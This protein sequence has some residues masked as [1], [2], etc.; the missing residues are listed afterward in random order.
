MADQNKF[1][2]LFK[3]EVIG[4]IEALT[5]IAPE[6]SEHKVENVSDGQLTTP[7]AQINI[8]IGGE[9]SGKMAIFV[10]VYL[11]TALGDMMLAGEGAGKDD[12]T[13]EDLDSIKEITSN[14]VGSFS[15][16]IS[17]QKKDFPSMS[18]RPLEAIFIDKDQS[19]NISDMK[20]HI[21]FNFNLNGAD[22]QYS[23]LLDK[24]YSDIFEK[25]NKKDTPKEE[26]K[27]SNSKD[28]SSSNNSNN[29][30]S[31]EQ[32]S[33]NSN[34]NLIASLPDE[35]IKNIALLLDVK[36][37]VKVRIGGKEMLLRDVLTMDIGSVVEL[38]QLA[39][40]ALDVLVDDHVIAKGEVIII[41][42]NFGVQITE[43]RSPKDRL[44]TIRGS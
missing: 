18:L 25:N 5:G 10:P 16:S 29:S 37:P 2:N 7:L 41:D 19:P 22:Y 15:T 39:N 38:N 23:I 6:L 43:I 42:G 24:V 9:V 33:N 14:I 20:K 40:E 26:I 27:N 8:S 12:M 1:F 34:N 3:N 11:A 31:S 17:S 30:K 28:N 13:D 21:K 4:T 36:L 44:N 32:E 35:E